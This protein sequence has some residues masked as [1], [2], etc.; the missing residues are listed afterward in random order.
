MRTTL[1]SDASV[2]VPH[3]KQLGGRRHDPSRISERH[4]G[5]TASGYICLRQGYA[6]LLRPDMEVP[7][8]RRMAY[9]RAFACLRASGDGD[10]SAESAAI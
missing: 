4:L 9:W 3:L 5:E 2:L 7:K 8:M 6:R 1:S 10:L